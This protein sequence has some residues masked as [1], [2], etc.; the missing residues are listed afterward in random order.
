MRSAGYL[1][2]ILCLAAPAVLAALDRDCTDNFI[3]EIAG[4]E[5][6]LYHLGAFY[7]CCPEFAYDVAL[8]GGEI[9]I[10]ET[11]V[12]ALCDCLCCLDLQVEIAE[13]P[14]GAYTLLFSW[15]DTEEGAWREWS[16]QIVVPAAG[17]IGPP[18]VMSFS[19]SG[20]LTVGTRTESWGAIKRRYQ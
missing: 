8:E 18:Q 4:G 3:V 7:N 9:R 10:Q 2:L 16:T 19:D 12:E 13:V 1:A 17:Q 5:V 6:T 11:E 20:C 15:L 14:A